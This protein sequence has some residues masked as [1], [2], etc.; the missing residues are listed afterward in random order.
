M[1]HILSRSPFTID[2]NA[3]LR[4]MRA[5]DELLLVQDGVIAAVEGSRQLEMLRAAPIS[6]SALREDLEARG[7]IAQISTEIDTVSY[8]DFVRLTVKHEQ[9]MTW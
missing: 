4:C 8:N 2:I 9:Q 6:I 3:L 7:L 1:L 5:E